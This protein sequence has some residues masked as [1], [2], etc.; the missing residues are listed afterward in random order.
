MNYTIRQL[1]IFIFLTNIA[2]AYA[3]MKNN[4]DR[5]KLVVGI[6]VD[7]MRW[8]YLYKYYQHYNNEG[9]KRMLNEGFSAE[10]TLIPYI[11]TY[12]AIGHTS[13]YA[14]SVPAIHGIAGNTFYIKETQSKMYCSQDD[15]VKSVGNDPENKGG[16]M[17]PKNMLSSSVTDELKLATDFRSRVFGVALKDRG[18]IFP[19]GHFADGAYWMVDGNWITSSFYMND[20]PSY[21]KNFNKADFTSAYL[22]K[23]WQ[24]AKPSTSY[25]SRIN[26]DNRYEERFLDSVKVTFP[27]DLSTISSKK[28]RDVI[29]ST[30]FGNTITL[31]F[32]KELITQENLGNNPAGVPDFLAISLSS[33]DYIGHQFAIN[34]LKIEDTYIRLDKDLG[35]F[36][37]FLDTKIGRGNYTVFLTADHGA[38]HNPQYILDEKG[39]GGYFMKR[40]LQQDL[41]NLLKPEFGTEDLI[42]NI[43][44][45]QVLLNHKLIESKN[46]DTERIKEKLVTAL[47]KRE[48]VSF[49][50]DMERLQVASMPEWIKTMAING[51]NYK[52][53]GDIL[54]IFDPQWIENYRDKTG[55][56]HGAWNPYDSH[57][58]LVFM[59]W[60]IKQGNTHAPVYMTD[61]APTIAAL[62]HIQAPNGCI[63]KPI[64]ELLDK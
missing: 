1:L 31:Q 59:G 29:K 55:T 47:K 3:Q 53:S 43:A 63:G 61:I 42:Y 20:L 17:S 60:G 25:M 34:S 45:N 40:E 11:P 39:N 13:I 56:T 30:P 19:A 58:P 50:T 26:D 64:T 57:I 16:K 18:A 37:N 21:V 36:F 14:G 23:G 38:A 27:I 46:L 12:T 41:N 9:L 6:V 8:D 33:T 54:I 62:L 28:G 7:Q 52:R 51:Y 2:V 10:N 4:N 35:D 24:L 22:S 32:A 44:N 48:G 5:P 49:A 15:S